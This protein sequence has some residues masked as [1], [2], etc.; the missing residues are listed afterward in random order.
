MDIET[1]VQNNEPVS[2]RETLE[3]NFAA[4]EAPEAPAVSTEQS[5]RVRDEHGRFAPQQTEQTA[6]PEVAP[7]PDEQLTKRELTTWKREMRPLHEKLARGEALSQDEALKLAQYNVER[8]QNYATGIS[9]Y[10]AKAEEAKEYADAMQDILPVLQQQ[11][12]PPGEFIRNVSNT[13]KVLVMGSPQEKL[14]MF[15]WLAQ[16]YGIPLDAIAPAQNGQYDPNQLQLMQK[17]QQLEAN[18][19][20]VAS[21]REQQEQ[22]AVQN[23]IAKFTD[24][25][26]YPH[27]EQVRGVMAQLLE[28][29]MADNLDSAYE[30][31]VRLDGDAFQAEQQRQATQQLAQQTTNKAAAAAK[32]RQASVSLKSS[33]PAGMV[34]SNVNPRNLRGAIEAAFDEVSGGGRV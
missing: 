19:N 22:A 30:K 12:M 27:F 26:K 24:A 14:Q 17:I 25:S 31:A 15:G 33:T 4:A 23:E 16:S 3:A 32:A 2:L 20:G 21:W 18:V 9:G 8:E 6:T 34:T 7:Q 1:E 13:H 29:G 10:K 28:T 5:G 11:N